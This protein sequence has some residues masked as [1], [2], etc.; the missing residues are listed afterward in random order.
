[1]RR[2]QVI[3]LEEPFLLLKGEAHFIE[4]GKQPGQPAREN[5]DN[6]NPTRNAGKIHWARVRTTLVSLL[7]NELR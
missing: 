6:E 3:S 4:Q 7:A 2:E 5:V 1:M